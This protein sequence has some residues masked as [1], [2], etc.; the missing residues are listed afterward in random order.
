[1]M[2]HFALFALRLWQP[3]L[4]LPAA[5]SP[6]KQDVPVTPAMAGIDKGNG[7]SGVD[8]VI[9]L[10]KLQPEIGAAG[11]C[12]KD[13]IIAFDF[14]QLAIAAGIFQRLIQA[15]QLGIFVNADDQGNFFGNSKLRCHGRQNH[16]KEKRFEPSAP[17]L[18]LWQ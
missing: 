11:V 5:Q 10:R 2:C 7:V 15:G 12:Q 18:K 3:P 4:M 14:K 1:V 6:I 9:K 17:F 13:Y 16:R 8:N